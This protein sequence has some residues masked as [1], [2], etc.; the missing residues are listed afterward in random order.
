MKICKNC[1]K[2]LNE[3]EFYVSGKYKEKVS[4]LNTCKKCVNQLRKTYLNEYRNKHKD[5]INK[6]KRRYFKERMNNVETRESINLNQRERYSK[7]AVKRLWANAKKRAEVKKLEFNLKLEDIII[8]EFCPILTIPIFTGTKNNYKN[9]P[10]L[11]RIDN[12]KGYVK[13]NIKVIS[14]LANTMKNSATK[15]Q[16]LTF[17]KNIITYLNNKDIVRTIEN[18]NL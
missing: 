14:T 7:Y 4:R 3:V 18:N 1:N 15:E 5:L 12:E 10:S 13:E 11:D 9:S 2:N 16:L 8:P 17:S 6:N